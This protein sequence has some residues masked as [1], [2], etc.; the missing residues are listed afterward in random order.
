VTKQPDAND[1]HILKS[2]GAH[3][4]RGVF[5]DARRARTNGSNGAGKST[6]HADLSELIAQRAADV[7]PERVEWLW[8]DRVAIGKQTLIAGEAGLGKS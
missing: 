1:I 7:S 2:G 8:P 5:D 4:L 6:D 3:A